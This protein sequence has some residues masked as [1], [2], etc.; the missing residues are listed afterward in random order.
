MSDEIKQ[1]KIFS[2]LDSKVLVSKVD[3]TEID[4][5]IYKN[6]DYD[7]DGTTRFEVPHMPK[8]EEGF[9]IGVIY[10]S[11]GSGKS[12]LL[13]NFGQE[14]AVEWDM[15]RSVASHFAS[16]EDAIARL[17][18][19]GL[20]T[21]PSWAKPRH[22]L[23]N[24]EGFRVDLARKLKDNAIIDE[25]TS[26]VNRDTAKS[27]S[28]ALSK[29]VKREGLKNIV[30]AT[31]HEDILSWLEPDWVYC[32][33]TQELKRGYHRQP[34]QFQVYRCDRSLWRMF[35]KHHY[36][37]SE[38]PD[39]VRCFCCIWENKLIG[40]ASAISLPGMLHP[41]YEGDKRTRWRECRTVILPDFQGLGIGVRFSNAVAD[42]FI[43]EGYR[44]FSKTAH[45][46]MGEYRE[47]SNL[48]R[49][50]DTNLKKRTK[51]SSKN[52]TEH[53]KHFPL[54]TI[55]ICYSHEYIGDDNKS[56]DPVWNKEDEEQKQRDLF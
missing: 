32:T 21:V 39:A 47:K 12:T 5:T 52:K 34:I 25:F 46:R 15:N 22:V 42:L 30:L 54:E 20:N 1:A 18:A 9:S 37:T 3:L 38:I 26:V 7:F 50:T 23:S 4:K 43:E 40:F 44:Y 35:A 31:C 55:R 11:S 36:L 29:Y 6:F 10:G 27:C 51:V 8:I 2:D 33:D 16:E 45:L 24:G 41:L 48:W 14:E 17:S 19:V 49:A 13:K 53:F 56:Y 28:V